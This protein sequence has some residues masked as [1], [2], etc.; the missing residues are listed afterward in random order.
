MNEIAE[1]LETWKLSQVARL[2][3][4]ILP[5]AN[6]KAECE[7]ALDPP[8]ACPQCGAPFLGT[9]PVGSRVVP[10]LFSVIGIAMALL[11]FLGP[12]FSSPITDLLGRL[13]AAVRFFVALGVVIPML[14][15][16]L[17]GTAASA[18]A[19][20]S[21]TGNY[22]QWVRFTHRLAAPTR[23]WNTEIEDGVRR[24]RYRVRVSAGTPKAT[25]CWLHC[26]SLLCRHTSLGEF[27]PSDVGGDPQGDFWRE[28]RRDLADEDERLLR[29]LLWID[30]VL[31]NLSARFRESG[32]ADI[33]AYAS[34]GPA[35]FSAAAAILDAAV[36]S[37][38]RTGSTTA[39]RVWWLAELCRSTA[40][41]LSKMLA[42]A[43]FLGT[44]TGAVFM[45]GEAGPRKAK[46]VISRDSTGSIAVYAECE[47]APA[48]RYT[49]AGISGDS[50]TVT[51]GTTRVTISRSASTQGS[52]TELSGS[53]V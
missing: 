45:L 48:A 26:R 46:Y 14:R 36:P 47:N 28:Y 5:C 7:V 13:P 17:A 9:R 18:S 50:L 2:P 24:T 22:E 39:E 33:T 29:D 27:A 3:P 23:Q 30:A 53:L 4:V 16:I 15:M 42:G 1:A 32:A 19:A 25:V 51:D 49:E 41:V 52:K 43:G 34:D 11:I 12:F 10:L 38:L 37:D 31:M 21:A 8:V 6:C 40:P 20:F 35:L 44:W